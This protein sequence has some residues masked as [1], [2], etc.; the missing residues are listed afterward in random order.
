MGLKE[1][2][3]NIGLMLC[4]TLLL[5][6]GLELGLRLF[7]NN[8][9]ADYPPQMFVADEELGYRYS[10]G[11]S[12]AFPAFPDI[13]IDINSKGLRDAERNYS[14]SGY[15]VLGLGDSVTFGAGV[16]LDETYLARLEGLMGHEVVKAGVNGWGF[17]QYRRF[18]E[19][20]GRKYEP[21]AVILALTLNDLAPE[22]NYAPKEFRLKTAEFFLSSVARMRAPRDYNEAYFQ[23]ILELWDSPE[24]FFAELE[25]FVAGLGSTR[26]IIGFFPYTQQFSK[27]YNGASPQQKL[28]RFAALHNT[29]FLDFTEVLEPGHYLQNDNV[30]LNAEGHWAVARALY[31]VMK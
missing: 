27:V 26:L 7:W 6:G 25:D 12:G 9:S 10:P 18:F 8:P 22:S 31:E 21:D 29:T 11:F 24:P 30:H 16:A 28:E 5:L 15:R 1:L 3:T 23:A 13:R 4:M 2:S 17:S 14:K 19:I 20:E